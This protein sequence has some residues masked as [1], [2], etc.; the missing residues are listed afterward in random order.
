MN[1]PMY[2]ILSVLVWKLSPS[3]T[4]L[5]TEGTANLLYIMFV[6]LFVFQFSQ[7]YKVNR[8]M[9]KHGAPESDKYEFKQVAV[10]DWAYFVTFGSELAVV[11]MLPGFSSTRLK[12]F[13]SQ[14]QEH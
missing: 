12:A 6:V 9:L 2:A 4:A 13:L 11:S 3:G 7:I 1:I 8:E 10:L 14:P 5:L